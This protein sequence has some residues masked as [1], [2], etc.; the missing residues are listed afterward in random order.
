MSL[1][2]ARVINSITDLSMFVDEVLLGWVVMIG[3]FERGPV[4]T[5][6]AVSSLDELRIKFGNKVTWSN[7]P[8]VAE[9]ALRQGGRLIIIRVVHYTDAADATSITALTSSVTLSDRGS[10]AT[11]ATMTAATGPYTFIPAAAGSITGTE[12]GPF[13]FG[14]G[15][16][17]KFK[18][19]VAAGSPQTVTF[20]ADTLVTAAEVA[21]IIN[22]QTTDLT[23]SATADEKVYIVA[24]TVTAGLTVSAV[25]NDA[26]STLGFSEAVTAAVAG[27]NKLVIAINGTA[28]Q[29]FTLVTAG[30]G[31][32]SFT[33][34]SSQ[35]VTQLAG[36]VLATAYSISGAVR[37]LTIG[38]GA[39][40][41]I[42]C[43]SGSTCLTA[44]G[45]TTTLIEGTTGV[46]QPTLQVD[47]R[48]PGLWGDSVLVQIW[49]SPL[50]SDTAF[51][52]KVVYSNQ[53]LTETFSDVN[54]DSTSDHYVLNY[55]NQRSE[56][57]YLTDLE[58]S[59]AGYT[60]RPVENTTGNALTGGS[61]GG[62]MIESDWIGNAVAQTGMYAADQTWNPAMD[63]MIPGT[64]SATV[65]QALI[66]YV[67]LRA[68]MIAYGEI[69]A[70]M[71][72][73]E[74]L[75]WRLGI[76]YGF[77]A[78][79]SH[80]FSLFYGRPLVYDDMDNTRKYISSLGHLAACL[81][82]TDNLYNTS[83]APVGPKRGKVTLC[84]GI[85]YDI[86]GYNSTGYADLFADNGINYLFIS[87]IK[88][89]Q[90]AMFW[91]QRT[92]WIPPTALR[93]LNVVRFIT[94]ANR[95]ILP[96]LETF[97]FDPN[98]PMT[99]RQIHRV[100][101]PAF[102]EFKDRYQIYDFLIQTDRDAYWDGKG[103]LLNAVIN[104]GLDISRGKYHCRALIQ[105]TQVIYYLMFNMGIVGAGEAFEQFQDLYELSGWNVR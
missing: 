9:M 74:A 22:A 55:V 8:L 93:N 16:N 48:N 18:I 45:L 58:S 64:N 63:I 34:T 100:L 41:S 60:N 88:G 3:Q 67:E 37:I 80:R 102:K 51:T 57:I 5:A 33:L 75:N 72:P 17:D 59:S 92:T 99:W 32:G 98:H 91:E 43:Q 54:M 46:T 20:P 26:Y 29:T 31:S 4:A 73:A 56:L 71:T 38:T 25:S 47:A 19:T 84:E 6:T 12:V 65:Y 105:P 96:V 82:K 89:I 1:G 39:S 94:S 2:A 62:T 79:N 36:L 97:L 87:R 104:T 68:D 103:N 85:D 77:G 23:A 83:Y 53:G 44:L 50:Q 90:G 66:A 10:T 40:V 101:E 70:N 15:I 76:G 13:N 14:T 27:T 35:I 86:R 49:P 78:W 69:P 81:C 42:K 95:M 7:D 28:D 30:E 11:R 61:D 21:D 52:L 24:N